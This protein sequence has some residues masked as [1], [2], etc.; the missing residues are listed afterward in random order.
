MA[1]AEGKN[2]RILDQETKLALEIVELKDGADI[3]WAPKSGNRN[4]LFCEDFPGNCIRVA[5][6]E[7]YVMQCDRGLRICRFNPMEYNQ[8]F[9][10]NGPRISHCENPNWVVT[11]AAPPAPGVRFLAGDYAGDRALQNFVYEHAPPSF[12][13]IKNASSGY[14]LDVWG[15]KEEPGTK[16]AVYGAN[17]ST[18][19]NDSKNQTWYEDRHGV[20]RSYLNDCSLSFD[21]ADKIFKTAAYDPSVA[22]QLWVRSCD[23][24]CL[25]NAPNQTLAQSTNVVGK[26]ITLFKGK[27]NE[28]D[29][30]IEPNHGTDNQK[31]SWE[32][33]F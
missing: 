19:A 23:R 32:Q 15:A 16:I 12:F 8:R 29:L 13:R 3:V 25:K 27:K 9:K 2:F 18:S 26:A 28:A 17:S 10:V 24:I 1:P 14:A 4:Q 11:S 31:W 30:C 5:S 22:N 33:V 6:D 7:S 21:P 20:I